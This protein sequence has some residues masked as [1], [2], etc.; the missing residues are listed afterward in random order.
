M[1]RNG[2]GHDMDNHQKKSGIDFIPL[3]GFNAQSAV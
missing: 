1:S 2:N 3:S